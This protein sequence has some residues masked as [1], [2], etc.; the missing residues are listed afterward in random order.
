MGGK[1][2]FAQNFQTFTKS[3]VICPQEMMEDVSH[4]L[5]MP[6]AAGNKPAKSMT[7]YYRLD[8]VFSHSLLQPSVIL[9]GGTSGP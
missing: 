4:R 6:Q 5:T 3:G 8:T 7:L 2:N 1:D 9:P